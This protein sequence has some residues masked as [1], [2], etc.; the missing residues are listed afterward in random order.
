MSRSHSTLENSNKFGMAFRRSVLEGDQ[1]AFVTILSLTGVK[2]HPSRCSHDTKDNSRPLSSSPSRSLSPILGR[3]RITSASLRP[4][5]AFS[6]DS[7]D[8]DGGG[9][10][11]GGGTRSRFAVTANLSFTLPERESAKESG[12]SSSSSSVHP[13]RVASPSIDNSSGEVAVKSV[14]IPIPPISSPRFGVPLKVHWESNRT[15]ADLHGKSTMGLSHLIVPVPGAQRKIPPHWDETASVTSDGLP[16]PS[17]RSR[18]NSRGRGS[19]S[20][21]GSLSEDQQGPSGRIQTRIRRFFRRRSGSH[22]ISSKPSGGSVLSGQSQPELD[23]TDDSTAAGSSISNKRD[24]SSRVGRDRQKSKSAP[25]IERSPSPSTTLSEGENVVDIS[26]FKNT[27][28][29]VVRIRVNLFVNSLTDIPLPI[30]R[31]CGFGGTAELTLNWEQLK[32]SEKSGIIFEI[33]IVRDIPPEG[34]LNTVHSPREQTPI[35]T[36]SLDS[37][38]SL[39]NIFG[40]GAASPP[41]TTMSGW[42]VA[43]AHRPMPPIVELEEDAILRIRVALGSMPHKDR[44]PRDHND[45]RMKIILGIHRA[46][47]NSTRVLKGGW[48]RNAH[49]PGVPPTESGNFHIALADSLNETSREDGENQED[50]NIMNQHLQLSPLPG[51]VLAIDP[52]QEPT[53]EEGDKMFDPFL[54]A[55]LAPEPKP[56]SFCAPL[57]NF[58]SVFSACTGGAGRGFDQDVPYVPPHRLDSS[59]QTTIDTDYSD[60]KAR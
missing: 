51:D 53:M 44:I 17:S 49:Q 10:G 41:D 3:G 60:I 37:M 29:G 1:A 34:Y 28:K 43:G 15:F 18:S 55:E 33:P 27:T 48:K 26:A 36:F 8:G 35:R 57:S 42:A 45:Q 40:T 59:L 24:Q 11:G 9:G 54:T 12:S 56:L 38:P 5:L 13:L 30:D 6:F 23:E 39:E 25:V 32:T 47:L 31:C 58:T 22:S 19:M 7:D 4:R 21:G 2:A 16:Q 46:S 20:A 50:W 52:N 14:P